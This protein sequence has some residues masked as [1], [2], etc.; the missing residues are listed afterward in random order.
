MEYTF[1]MKAMHKS[2]YKLQRTIQQSDAGTRTRYWITLPR[3]IIE[4]VLRWRP[5]LPYIVEYIP[6]G[7]TITPKRGCLLIYQGDSVWSD[8]T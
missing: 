1:N 4:Q 6:E 3:Q 7:T 5:G 2:I 8:G